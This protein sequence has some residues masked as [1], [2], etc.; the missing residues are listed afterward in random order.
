MSATADAAI[1]AQNMY[2]GMKMSLVKR[3]YRDV[4]HSPTVFDRVCRSL[5]YVIHIIIY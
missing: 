1:V 5:S 4:Q 2:I 3:I